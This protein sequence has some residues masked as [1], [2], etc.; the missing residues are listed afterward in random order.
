VTDDSRSAVRFYIK[1][2]QTKLIFNCV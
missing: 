1:L 2:P